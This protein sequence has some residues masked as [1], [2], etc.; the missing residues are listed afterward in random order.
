M[1]PSLEQL[2]VLDADAIVAYQQQARSG[3]VDA[4]PLASLE[5]SP[6]WTG[7]PAVANDDVFV[8]GDA[9]GLGVSVS[10]AQVLLADLVDTVFAS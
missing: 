1:Y 7:L 9:W 8:F 3:D 5:A 2:D 10:A 4:D 6:L